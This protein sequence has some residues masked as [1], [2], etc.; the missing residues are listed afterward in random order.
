[1]LKLKHMYSTCEQPNKNRIMPSRNGIAQGQYLMCGNAKGITALMNS[2]VYVNV[3]V[4]GFI[5]LVEHQSYLGY[6]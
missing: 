2:I 4:S 1:M 3:F 6:S 5:S